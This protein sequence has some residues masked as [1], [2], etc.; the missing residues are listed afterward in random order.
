MSDNSNS[1]KKIKLVLQLEGAAIFILATAL[2][3]S[4]DMSWWFY[5]ALILAPDLAMIGYAFGAKIGTFCYNMAHNYIL[6]VGLAL[7]GL[8]FDQMTLISIALIWFAHIGADRLLQYGLKFTSGFKHTH[9]N[10]IKGI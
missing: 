1:A 9:I 3:A 7:A 10:M 2:Y 6:P 4:F 5:A 8:Q